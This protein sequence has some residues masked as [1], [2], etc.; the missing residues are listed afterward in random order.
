[1]WRRENI[2]GWEKG[3]MT[4]KCPLRADVVGLVVEK[5]NPEADRVVC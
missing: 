5:P 2:N 4:M 3:I 1:M